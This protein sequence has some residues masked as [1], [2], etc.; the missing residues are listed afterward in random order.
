MSQL[1]FYYNT[2]RERAQAAGNQVAQQNNINMQFTNDAVNKVINGGGAQEFASKMVTMYPNSVDENTFNQE[3]M[4]YIKMIVSYT[5]GQ[6]GQ[7]MTGGFGFQ[8]QPQQQQSMFGAQPSLFS[9]PA[10]G[11]QQQPTRQS[12][13]VAPGTVAPCGGVHPVATPQN[14]QA[15]T[16]TPQVCESVPAHVPAPATTTT[17]ESTPVMTDES[18]KKESVITSGPIDN[19]KKECSIHLDE[20]IGYLQTSGA[21][22]MINGKELIRNRAQFLRGLNNYREAIEI[23]KTT[24]EYYTGEKTKNFFTWIDFNRLFTINCPTAITKQTF[25]AIQESIYVKAA[26]VTSTC[27]NV[28]IITSELENLKTKYNNAIARYLIDRINELIRHH[29]ITVRAAKMYI[30]IEEKLLEVDHIINED[31]KF[32]NELTNSTDFNFL[33]IYEE[34]VSA[35]T[36]T[37]TKVETIMDPDSD[38][39]FAECL[40]SL[41]NQT[42]IDGF[43]NR[44]YFELVSKGDDARIKAFHDTIVGKTTMVAPCAVG[45]TNKCPLELIELEMGDIHFVRSS[46]GNYVDEFVKEFYTEYYPAHLVVES[47]DGYR[48]FRIIKSMEDFL[49]YRRIN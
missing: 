6:A 37:L 44:N 47:P 10:A 32:I 16:P 49:G 15:T 46:G 12:A 19:V 41:Q 48:E 35:V 34:V 43:N 23:I 18:F 39:G 26:K 14:Q 20:H 28:G 8:Q 45:Y 29:V 2:A 27:G 13:T 25:D 36:N 1:Q 9:N 40:Y 24:E 7:G 5:M 38:Q 42:C 17:I 22:Y 30:A 11:F 33:A 4:N 3:L 21:K 31:D